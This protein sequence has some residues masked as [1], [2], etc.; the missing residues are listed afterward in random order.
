MKK[1]YSK[2]QVKEIVKAYE[3][4]AI[5]ETEKTLENITRLF[6][7]EFDKQMKED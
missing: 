3:K 5:E 4:V 2:K 7:E 1:G 6:F